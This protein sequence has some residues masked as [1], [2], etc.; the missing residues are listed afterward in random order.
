MGARVLAGLGAA[1]NE[2]IMTMVVADI[3]FLHER[4]AFVGLYL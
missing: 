4:G 3:F 2:S 1:A